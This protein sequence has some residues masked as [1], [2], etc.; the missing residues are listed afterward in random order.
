MLYC[1]FVDFNW[2]EVGL[3]FE[4]IFELLYDVYVFKFSDIELI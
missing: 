1:V 3:L 2:C 4:V